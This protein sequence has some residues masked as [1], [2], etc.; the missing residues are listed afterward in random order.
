[1]NRVL[2][3]CWDIAQELE[4]IS[5]EVEK[6]V[7]SLLQ[8]DHI[9]VQELVRDISILRIYMQIGQLKIRELAEVLIDE[10]VKIGQENEFYGWH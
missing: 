3:C 2:G 7:E 8:S 1:M 9:R 5:D 6:L 10:N 4:S